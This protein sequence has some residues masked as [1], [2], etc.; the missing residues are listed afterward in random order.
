MRKIMYINGSIMVE[1]PQSEEKLKKGK[2]KNINIKKK[3]IKVMRG[4]KRK[5]RS[6]SAANAI[7][8][9]E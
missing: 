4:H 7:R 9:R 8:I 6:R 1:A 2:E 3:I 5:D